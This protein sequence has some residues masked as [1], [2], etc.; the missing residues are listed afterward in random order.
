MLMRNCSCHEL[1]ESILYYVRNILKRCLISQFILFGEIVWLIP[2]INIYHPINT[3]INY[4]FVPLSNV[5][6][7][8][9]GAQNMSADYV[10]T[11]IKACKVETQIDPFHCHP[12]SRNRPVYLSCSIYLNSAPNGGSKQQL[13]FVF[14]A[15][16]LLTT[17]CII[18]QPSQEILYY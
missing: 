11:K 1:T 2:L 13:K 9:S 4:Q 5:S 8:S 7:I 3:K 16:Y 6:C 12:M 14:T 10:C 15:Q 18:F 17:L